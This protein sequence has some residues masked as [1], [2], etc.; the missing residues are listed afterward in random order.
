HH[1]YTPPPVPPTTPV[2]RPGRQ[3][4]PLDNPNDGVAWRGYRR[5]RQFDP[6]QSANG[7]QPAD[8]VPRPMPAITPMP[9]PMRSTSPAPPR[10]RQVTVQPP[11]PSFSP[12]P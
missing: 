5:A 6:P 12:P 3:I 1:H 4:V 8:G 11:A 7:F 2:P 9:P 10:I